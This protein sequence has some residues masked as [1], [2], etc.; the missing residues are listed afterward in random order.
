LFSLLQIQFSKTNKAVVAMIKIY[1][2]LHFFK[3]I[4]FLM[5]PGLPMKGPEKVLHATLAHA[6]QLHLGAHI[7]VSFFKIFL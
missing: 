6:K 5:F 7:N 1:I 3:K 4:P 2:Y